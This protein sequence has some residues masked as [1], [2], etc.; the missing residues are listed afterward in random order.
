MSQKLFTVSDL[1]GEIISDDSEHVS[2]VVI[3]HPTIEHSVRLDASES[4]IKSLDGTAADFAII[5]VIR[6]TGTERLVVELSKFEKLF[7]LDPQEALE[8]ADSLSEPAQPK[9]RGRPAGAK[10]KGGSE[11]PKSSPEQLEATR[12]WARANG[13]PELSSRGRI[14]GAVQAA[15]DAAHK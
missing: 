7:T 12:S 2:I 15:F 10:N 8:G 13:W 4:E 6:S 1:T 14:P 3:D 5:E 11:K 9:R